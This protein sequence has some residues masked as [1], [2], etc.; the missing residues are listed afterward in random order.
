MEKEAYLGKLTDIAEKVG[1]ELIDILTDN[2]YGVDE[3]ASIILKMFPDI[4][5]VDLL[6]GI[7]YYNSF[8]EKHPDFPVISD[9]EITEF[10]NVDIGNTSPRDEDIPE[11]REGSKIAQEEFDTEEYEYSVDPILD[12]EDAS[13]INSIDIFHGVV[14]SGDDWLSGWDSGDE[15]V[16]LDALQAVRE[17]N[18]E[19]AA[20]F[21][22]ELQSNVEKYGR[23]AQEEFE[24]EPGE[25]PY[26]Y[27]IFD[28]DPNQYS[29][30]V[31]DRHTDS[32]I[33]AADDDEAEEQVVDIM[34]SAAIGLSR[35]DGYSVGDSL[36]AAIWDDRGMIIA[37]P[38][39]TLTEEHLGED[40]SE[41]E[42]EEDFD[43]EDSEEDSENF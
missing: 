36:Y 4:E 14:K 24:E 41:E 6:N 8:A 16:A 9:S 35:E 22:G 19:D 37:K 38:I 29:N 28:A 2:S 1:G 17:G 18:L 12:E 5:T 15:E 7:D 32:E 10:F 33:W 43:E 42:V 26:T 11:P 21:I 40:Y 34:N 20:H 31:W 25:K 27:T 13:A 39:I 23:T 3:A 30:P